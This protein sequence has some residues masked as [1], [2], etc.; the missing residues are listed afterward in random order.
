MVRPGR[1]GPTESDDYGSY[2]TSVKAVEECL[3]DEKAKCL[4]D[5]ESEVRNLS[6]PPPIWHLK[7]DLQGVKQVKK[8]P[9]FKPLLVFVAPPSID[10]LKTRLGGRGTETEESIQGRLNIALKEIEY[11]KVRLL[12]G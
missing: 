8:L 5:I 9:Q 11:A 4:L 6:S 7:R 1:S 10:D 12:A 2:G 3:K